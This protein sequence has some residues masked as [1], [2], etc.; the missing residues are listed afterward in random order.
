VLPAA[1]TRRYFLKTGGALYVL[2]CSGI[3]STCWNSS[4]KEGV[5]LDF[6]G[7]LT[8][9]IASTK[10][11]YIGFKKDFCSLL[12]TETGMDLKH[13][14]GEWQKAEKYFATH[15]E[16][17][18][19]DYNG[20]LT[21]PASDP[22]LK[23]Q[24]IAGSLLTKF[25]LRG[26]PKQITDTKNE[27]F[28]AHY[29]KSE[30]VYRPGAKEFLEELV[31]RFPLAIITNSGTEKVEEDLEKLN[32]RGL[33]QIALFGNAK[34]YLIDQE[35][36]YLPSSENCVSSERPILLRRR[37]YYRVLKNLAVEWNKPFTNFTVIGDIYDLDLA[38]P[39]A[40]GARTILLIREGTYAYEKEMAEEVVN[41]L[42]ELRDIL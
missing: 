41:S 16:E 42:D 9:I 32:P 10:E 19:W 7:T 31:E 29:K 18:S 26:S 23:A 13:A 34:K 6:D 36:K 14:E 20:H 35:W 3:F 1:L 12:Q 40:L 38:L 17:F 21:A 22:Y 37:L 24:E 15:H 39:K 27:L 11:F 25:H 5:I 30:T 28:L 4:E 8:D 2:G 33:E